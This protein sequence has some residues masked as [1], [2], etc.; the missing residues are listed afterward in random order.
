MSYYITTKTDVLTAQQR[1]QYNRIKK[2]VHLHEQ[3]IDDVW[4]NLDHDVTDTIDGDSNEA[5]NFEGDLIDFIFGWVMG[6]KMNDIESKMRMHKS[7]NG[8][9]GS[10][11]K[12]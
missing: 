2:I 11:K 6:E 8:L 9:V 12:K 10:S 7:L 4:V 1:E 3:L 5:G